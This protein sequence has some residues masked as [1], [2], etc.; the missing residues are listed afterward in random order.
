MLSWTALLYEVAEQGGGFCV[1]LGRWIGENSSTAAGR[2]GSLLS[3][4]A[5]PFEMGHGSS[6][7]QSSYGSTGPGEFVALNVCEACC[8]GAFSGNGD[9]IEELGC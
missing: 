8:S 2:E 1:D 6:S 4:L 7:A 9:I 5:L 3:N